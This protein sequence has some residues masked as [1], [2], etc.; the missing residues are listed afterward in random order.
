MGRAKKEFMKDGG[1][2]I[3]DAIKRPGALHKALHVPEDKKIP[4]S[5]MNKALHSS[6]LRIRE[7]ANLAKTLK[8]FHH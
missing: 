6:N 8:R 3:K 4:T 1:Y 5:K 2:W 7:E